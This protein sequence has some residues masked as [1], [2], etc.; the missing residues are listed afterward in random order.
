MRMKE[1][2]AKID[3]SNGD[4]IIELRHAIKDA[5]GKA[6]VATSAAHKAWRAEG[7][8]LRDM[9]VGIL[10]ELAYRYLGKEQTEEVETARF[11]AKRATSHFAVVE[12]TAV[13]EKR[14]AGDAIDLVCNLAEKIERVAA[15]AAGETDSI[16]ASVAI[17]D[18]GKS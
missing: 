7:D 5:I 6:R 15:N 10:D 17:P 13:Q 12:A 8:A 4:P 1:V 2:Q 14:A 11:K 3:K 16:A 18:G 9:S